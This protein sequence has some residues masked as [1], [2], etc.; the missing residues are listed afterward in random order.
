MSSSSAL[1]FMKLLGWDIQT[2][3]K[4]L[5]RK[6]IISSIMELNDILSYQGHDNSYG[7]F[8]IFMRKRLSLIAAF[9]SIETFGYKSGFILFNIFIIFGFGI[10]RFTYTQ[11]VYVL[12][13]NWTTSH[14][15]FSTIEFSSWH[16]FIYQN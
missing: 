1:W 10:Y 8:Y 3:C 16:R 5:L 7:V 13:H 2:F 11:I 9:F 4:S 15:L 12:K 14:A 6:T